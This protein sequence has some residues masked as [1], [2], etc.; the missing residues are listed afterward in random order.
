MENNEPGFW[1]H[2]NELR[3][4]LIRSVIV[5]FAFFIVAFSFREILFDRFLLVLLDPNFITYKWLMQLGAFTGIGSGEAISINFILIN[6]QLAG[7]FMAHI[8]LSALAGFVLSIPFLIFQ[9]WLF[10][11]PALYPNESRII[12]RNTVVLIFLFLLGCA[13]AYF[14]ITPLSVVFL[15]NYTISDTVKNTITLGSY[16]S[17]FSSSLF[18][19]GLLFELPV[20]MSILAKIGIV[21]FKMLKRFRKH[22]I[23]VGLSLSAIITPTTDPFTMTVVAIPLYLLFEVSIVI[24]HQQERR[25]VR[26]NNT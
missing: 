7:Q 24:V 1:D 18:L 4:Y 20:L 9:L 22:A 8:T 3:K 25:H 26:K 10:V 16:L 5:F 6:T 11:K 2:L 15:G 13:F 19:T 23:V 14:I 17:V 12:K 21:S